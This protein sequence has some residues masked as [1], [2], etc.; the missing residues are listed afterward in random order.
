MNASLKFLNQSHTPTEE[1]AACCNNIGQVYQHKG[2]LNLALEYSRKALN[3]LLSTRRATPLVAQDFV[4][5][6][7]ILNVMKEFDQTTD[8]IEK[9]LKIYRLFFDTLNLGIGY[10]YENPLLVNMSD[11]F[12]TLNILIKQ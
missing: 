6:S 5:I 8:T 3:I 9:A 1:V 7:G 10:C 12:F 2:S 4:N 11:A